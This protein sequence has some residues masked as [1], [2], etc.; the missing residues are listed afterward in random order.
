[1][2]REVQLTKERV[3][4]VDSDGGMEEIAWELKKTRIWISICVHT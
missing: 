4:S 1:M 3:M 2:A